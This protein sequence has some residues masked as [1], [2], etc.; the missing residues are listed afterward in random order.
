M[1]LLNKLKNVCPACHHHFWRV[2]DIKGIKFCPECHV[3]LYMPR[4]NTIVSKKNLQKLLGLDDILI[5]FIVALIL[6]Y[7]VQYASDS[8]LGYFISNVLTYFNYVFLVLL[9]IF[10]IY[11][12]TSIT[13]PNLQLIK[14]Q[15]CKGVDTVEVVQEDLGDYILSSA[16][17]R[18]YHI[19][20]CADCRSQRLQHIAKFKMNRVRRHP[21]FKSQAQ[22]CKTKNHLQQEVI[23]T[24]I[25]CLRC[26]SEFEIRSRQDSLFAS[27]LEYALLLLL[28]CSLNLGFADVLF[29]N[30]P[31]SSLPL[32]FST[33]GK[34]LFT[35][36]FIMLILLGLKIT[37]RYNIRKKQDALQIICTKKAAY[38]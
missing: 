1:K 10:C 18:K 36:F 15:L 21:Q 37:T 5:T 8:Q 23:I 20:C 38:E 30:L 28:L 13:F 22:H 24:P 11:F 3:S 32:T 27:L 19:T 31:L 16:V 17:G 33:Q 25:G 9:I 6:V 4:P 7:I 29:S 34:Y 14:R 2:I 26:Q 12:F 35:V